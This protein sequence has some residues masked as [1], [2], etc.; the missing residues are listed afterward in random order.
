MNKK[1]KSPTCESSVVVYL[2]FV[3]FV[4][5]IHI[6]SAYTYGVHLCVEDRDRP[7]ML[8]NIENNINEQIVHE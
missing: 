1:F 2:V 4:I 3:L 5:L 7:Y 8:S 6:L